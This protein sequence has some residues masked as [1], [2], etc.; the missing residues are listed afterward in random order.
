MGDSPDTRRS[1]AVAPLI[2]DPRGYGE[3]PVGPRWGYGSMN[4]R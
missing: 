2:P 3:T 4:G 1:L